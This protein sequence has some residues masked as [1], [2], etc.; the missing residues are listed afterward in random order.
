MV[1]LETDFWLSVLAIS[2]IVKRVQRYLKATF[3]SIH[4]LSLQGTFY[5]YFHINVKR[6]S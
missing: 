3:P 6:N 2:S 1:S 5:L 4:Q